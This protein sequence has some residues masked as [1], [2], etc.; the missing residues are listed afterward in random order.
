M[1]QKGGK[2]SNNT[3]TLQNKRKF[4][5][6]HANNIKKSSNERVLGESSQERHWLR[7]GV[8]NVNLEHIS[9]LVSDLNFELVNADWELTFAPKNSFEKG[10]FRYAYIY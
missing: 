5:N 1:F 10:N 6:N 8:F 3:L 9:H 2:L 7:S 4:Q